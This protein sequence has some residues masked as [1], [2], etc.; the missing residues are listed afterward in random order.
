MVILL[1]SVQRSLS[2]RHN[3]I[4]LYELGIGTVD[5]SNKEIS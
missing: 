2:F 5:Y 4:T 3:K 1:C